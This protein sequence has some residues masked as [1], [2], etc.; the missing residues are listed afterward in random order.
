MSE[1]AQEQPVIVVDIDGVLFDT[2]KQAIER[3]NEI[4][5]TT[6]AVTDIYD[7][8]A[9]HDKVKFRHYHD[10]GKYDEG[11]GQGK[12]DDGFYDGQKEVDGYIQM[13]G[14]RDALARLRARGAKIVALTSRDPGKLREETLNA[15][16]SHFGIGHDKEGLI[17]EV[18]FAGDPDIPGGHSKKSD[19]MKAI[20]GKVLVDDAVR[21]VTDAAEAG[22]PAI[23]LAQPYNK[24]GHT[25]PPEKTADT[26]ERAEQLIEK[27]LGWI[28]LSD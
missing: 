15:I 21:Y 2:P 23:L 8:D 25:W 10:D 3:W 1:V 14:A 26:W 24:I 5:G 6:H 28:E 19:I 13:E 22:L 27:E 7:H 11:N 17:D 16:D 18:L 20:G 4:H 9:V 12:F